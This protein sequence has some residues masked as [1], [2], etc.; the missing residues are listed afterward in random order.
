MFEILLS[1]CTKNL[2]AVNQTS[3]IDQL[4]EKSDS[5]D[6]RLRMSIFPMVIPYLY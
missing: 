4:F 2:V 1:V 5:D 6:K 3:K